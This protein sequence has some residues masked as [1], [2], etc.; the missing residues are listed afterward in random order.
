MNVPV[1]NIVDLSKFYGKARGIEHINLEIEEGEIFGFIG[2]NG[3]G[4][5][6]TIRILMN[7]IFP[8]GGSA[9]IM[10]MDVIRDTKRIKMQVGYIPSDASAYS[11]MDVHE[12]LNYCINFYQLQNGEKRISELSDLFELDLNRKI[13][14]LSLGNRKKVSII[15]S[16]LHSPRLLILDEPT[17]GLDPLMQSVFFELLRSENRKGMTIFFS[18]HILAEVQML[19]KRVAII[20]EG[21]IIQLEDI[22]NLRKKQLKKVSVEFEDH[23]NIERFSIQGIENLITG[24]GNTITFMYSGNI[25]E[26][27]G[28]LS[29]KQINNLTIEE[30]S[31]DEIFLHYYKN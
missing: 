3:A 14:D 27:T 26:L 24:P 25:N 10:G 4:K 8:S 29:G 11:S 22:D 1:I 21:K 30:P 2:P 18:S 19:C 15:Q 7:L 12:F 17:T 16:L 28:Y 9:K 23:M 31:L 5:S 6:T 13:A 20:K